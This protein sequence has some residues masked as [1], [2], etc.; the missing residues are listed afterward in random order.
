M[1][2]SLAAAAALATLVVTSGN[3]SA[4]RTL[5]AYDYCAQS[6]LT[7]GSPFS[8]AGRIADIHVIADATDAPVGWIYRSDRGRSF[9][10]ANAKMSSDDQ[11]TL[12]VASHDAVSNLRAR[13]TTLPEGLH[14]RPCRASEIARY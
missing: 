10:Q 1:K 5:H 11:A 7:V 2:H 3:A 13:P 14:I 8:G 4:Q 6:P 12:G 9:L